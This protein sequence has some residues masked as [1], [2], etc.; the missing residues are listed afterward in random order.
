MSDDSSPARGQRTLFLCALA[1]LIGAIILLVAVEWGA[2][3]GQGSV[4]PA[5]SPGPSSSTAPLPEDATGSD[6]APTIV[7]ASGPTAVR[8]FA[9]GNLAPPESLDHPRSPLADSLQE[10]AGTARRDLATLGNLFAHFIGEFGEL[11]V[12]NNAEITAALAGDNARAYAVLPSDHPAIN[13]KG[14]LIDRWGTPY[15]FH[16]LSREVMEVRSA[17]PDQRRYTDD[18]IVWPEAHARADSTTLAATDH[19]GPSAP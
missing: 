15:F 17:G 16:Q 1:L 4:A 5:P 13:G 12:G 2:I 19:E 8:A 3:V 14:E 6:S 10:P 9:S 18:D 7:V 11:P